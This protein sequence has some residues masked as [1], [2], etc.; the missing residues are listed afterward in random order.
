LS[1]EAL[2]EF[3]EVQIKGQDLGGEGMDGAKVLC[4]ANARVVVGAAGF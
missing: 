4:T 3:R 2:L 1:K